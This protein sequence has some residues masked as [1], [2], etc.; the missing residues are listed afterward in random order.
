MPDLRKNDE[1]RQFLVENNLPIQYNDGLLAYLRAYYN[2]TNSTLNDLLHRYIN[3]VGYTLAPLVTFS[4]DFTLGV[5]PAEYSFFRS[6]GGTYVN[7]SGIIA[8]VG[9]AT[10]RFGYNP[11]TLAARGLLL[12]EASTNE[13]FFS[14]AIDNA[15]Y[16]KI[17]TS[18]SA[19]S[20]TSPDGTVSADSLIENSSLGTHHVVKFGSNSVTSAD[21]VAFSVFVKAGSGDRH[22]RMTGAGTSHSID[23]NADF[24]LSDGSSSISGATAIEAYS[25]QY[26]NGWWRLTLISQADLTGTYSPFVRMITT[27][28]GSTSYTGNGTSFIYVWGLQVEVNRYASSFIYTTTAPVFRAADIMLLD[29]ANFS[30]FFNATEGTFEIETFNIHDYTGIYLSCEGSGAAN[31]MNIERSSTNTL[32]R[33]TASST[34]YMNSTIAG[35]TSSIYMKMALAYKQNDSQLAANGTEGTTD[36]SVTLPVVNKFRFRPASGGSNFFLKTFNYWNTRKTN[37]STITT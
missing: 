4:T 12:E 36:T 25:E 1:V 21:F 22:V 29:G 10:P 11:T 7:S 34:E 37:L 8:S 18:V 20:T 31:A 23:A 9:S 2:V 6:T 33:I 3:E 28:G 15:Y 32:G 30:S 17:N 24:D 27:I 14:T 16:S 35:N 19:N 5:L 26:P 13:V